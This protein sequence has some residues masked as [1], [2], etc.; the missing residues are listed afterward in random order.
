MG[1]GGGYE[2]WTNQYKW[3]VAIYF[4]ISRIFFGFRWCW[5]LHASCFHRVSF[6]N[7]DTSRGTGLIPPKNIPPKLL[8][9]VLD[10]NH[11]GS[12]G[13][14]PFFGGGFG[15][16]FYIYLHSPKLTWH[17]PQK[18]KP[19]K[20]THLMQTWVFFLSLLCSFF[21][22]R[23]SKPPIFFVFWSLHKSQV[24]DWKII[25]PLWQ[26]PGYPPSTA[27]TYVPLV[28]W[29]IKSNDEFFSRWNWLRVSNIWSNI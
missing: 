27:E 4:F 14:P 10:S 6:W 7:K 8:R 23:G 12:I 5:L 16:N 2:I 19:K 15:E 21:R 26:V 1:V 28:P 13:T 25:H 9:V 24:A 18:P 17:L 29:N 11:L 20:E 3:T 22:L